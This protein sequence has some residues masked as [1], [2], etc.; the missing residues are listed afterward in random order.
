MLLREDPVQTFENPLTPAM[1][2]Y[3]LEQ[4]QKGDEHAG[5]ILILHNM[6]LVA[7]MMKRY[8]NTQIETAELLSVGTV[9]LIKSVRTFDPGKGS[10]FATYAAKCIENEFLMAFRNEKKRRRE[11]SLQEPVGTDKEGNAINIIDVVDTGEK[12]IS[13][14]YITKC[15]VS[16]LYQGIDTLLDDR[17]KEIIL[18][19][20]GLCGRTE[21]TQRDLAKRLGI[22][23]SYVSRIE[24]KALGKL[25]GIF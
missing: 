13:E 3:Y 15:E 19:R 22:S 20:Y 1:E 14:Q 4:Y 7:H 2:R 23:R 25:R 17:E 24:K 12:D 10:R 11:V 16:R 18:C 5:E 21:T 9:G 8:C 6:R